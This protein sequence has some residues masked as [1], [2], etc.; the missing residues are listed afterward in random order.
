MASVLKTGF[1][2]SKLWDQGDG[3]VQAGE[4]AGTAAI[5]R[6]HV[7]AHP[8]A[9]S[10]D[11]LLGTGIFTQQAVEALSCLTARFNLNPGLHL[12][13]PLQIESAGRAGRWGRP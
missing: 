13:P 7:D 2:G 11:R 12:A 4:T 6:R 3:A 1:W 9:G 8:I 5:T 10:L